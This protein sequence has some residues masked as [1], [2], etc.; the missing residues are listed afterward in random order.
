MQVASEIITLTDDVLQK[1]AKVC[2]A[3]NRQTL[4]SLCQL[5][6]LLFNLDVGRC[7]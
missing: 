6:K 2:V 1:L 3:H 5:A 4:Q 7:R